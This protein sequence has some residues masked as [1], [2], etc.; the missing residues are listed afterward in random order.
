MLTNAP[1]GKSGPTA[2]W[3]AFRCMQAGDSFVLEEPVLGQLAGCL[4]SG[5]LGKFQTHGK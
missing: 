1:V 2:Q 4:G 5:V 3:S